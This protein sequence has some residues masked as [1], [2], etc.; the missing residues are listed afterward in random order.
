VKILVVDVGGS[1]LKCVAADRM[2]PAKFASGPML[3][4]DQLVRKVLKVTREWRFDAVSIGY[5]G[6][7]GRGKRPVISDK[8]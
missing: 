7:A 1:H 6:V 3:T 4:P 2:S 5:P 8:R